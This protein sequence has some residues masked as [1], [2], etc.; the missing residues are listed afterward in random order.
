MD[1]TPCKKAQAREASFLP[2]QPRGG[3]RSRKRGGGSARVNTVD[4]DDSYDDKGDNIMRVG[5]QKT[6]RDPNDPADQAGDGRPETRSTKVPTRMGAVPP[7]GPLT[8]TS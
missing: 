8:M 6:G 1:R 2:P 3:A 4:K 7:L 5:R